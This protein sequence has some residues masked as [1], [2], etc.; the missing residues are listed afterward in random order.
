MAIPDLQ[1][2]PYK[3][4]LIN[5]ELDIHIFCFLNCF[6]PFAVSLQSD[7]RISSFYAEM[8]KL[9]ELTTSPE[10]LYHNINVK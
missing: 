9:S 2:Y 8:E 10:N 7:L 1:R 3:L 6:F 4:D 5:C